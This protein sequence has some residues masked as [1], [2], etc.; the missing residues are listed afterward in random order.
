MS[1][2][3]LRIERLRVEAIRNSRFETVSR[4]LVDGVSLSLQRG[5]VLGLIGESGAG[6]STIG[7]AAMGYVRPGCNITAGRVV[8]DGLD[9]RKVA[10]VSMRSLWGARIAYVAQSA[11]ASLNPA[12]RLGYQVAEVLVLHR[13]MDWVTAHDRAATLFAELD[14]PSPGTFGERFPHQVSGGQLQRA[15]IAMA[16]AC[17]PELLILDEP[18]TALDVTTQIEVLASVRRLLQKL[19]TAAIYITHDLPLIVQM[20]DRIAVLRNGQLVEEG[21]TRAILER[22]IEDYTRRLIATQ[23][24]TEIPQITVSA[25]VR[26][27][28]ILSVHR[29]DAGYRTLP[30]ALVDVSFTLNAGETLAIVGASGS[31]KSTLARVLC[32]LLPQISGS[33]EFQGTPLP[34]ALQ[35]RTRDQLRRIQMIYQTPDTAL[36]PSQRVSRII[37]RAV[38]LYFGGSRRAVQE[39]VAELL[40]MV[41]LPATYATRLPRELSGGEKQ[42]VCIARALAARPD[43]IV[44]DEITSALDPLVADEILCLL[45]SLQE[46]VNT[47]YLFITHNIEVVR[48]IA[49]HV[50]VI[51]SGHI[52]ACGPIDSVFSLPRHPHLDLLLSAVPT[53]DP[54]WLA[55]IEARQ[56]NADAARPIGQ[57]LTIGQ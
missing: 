15:M 47:T 53:M 56:I 51:E 11:A 46:S 8:F 32:G 43:L 39:R 44:C 41:G 31:G 4:P 18:T 13:K 7:L 14:L 19:G 20:A 24:R 17:N 33:I 23:S 22:P 50:A 1:G 34:R 49:S 29:I 12:M 28:P 27:Q 37:G 9:L 30:R 45:R 10:P 40:D 26:P 3:L 54:E 35:H 36:N 55:T 25:I 48:R 38:S 5:E 52:V 21:A 6:K 57:L 2:P 42:R 16:M